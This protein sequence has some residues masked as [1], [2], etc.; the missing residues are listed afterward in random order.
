MSGTTRFE[1]YLS[2]R[3]FFRATLATGSLVV[4]PTFGLAPKTAS[5]FEPNAFVRIDPDGQVTIRVARPEL[6]QGVHTSLP[7][8]VAEELDVDWTQIR[9]EPAL[10]I[11]RNVYGDQYAGGS[12]SVRNG[13]EPLRRAGAIARAMLVQAAARRWHVQ[14]SECRTAHGAV[15]HEPSKRHLPYGAL[16]ARAASLPVPKDVP[17]K[18]ANQYHFIGRPM[19]QRAT[20]DIV[21]GA[22]VFGLDTRLPGMRYASIEHA[23][24]LGARVVA[25]DESAARSIAGVRDVVTVN[26]D[27]LPGFGDNNPR[28]ANGV[29]VIADSTWSALKGRRALKVTWSEGAVEEDTEQRRTE[30]H[31]LSA[32]PP[33]RVVRSDGDVERA[34]GLATRTL[35]AVYEVP[36]LAHVPMEPMNCVADVRADRCDV[37]APTQNPAA[38]RSVAAA[39]CG[40][41]VESVTVHTRRC[42]GGFGRRF[43]ADYVAEATVLSRAAGKPVQVMWTREDDVR[44]DY[45]RPASC[46]QMRAALD[47]RGELVAWTQH[48]VQA[49]RGDFLQWAPPA[50]ET[51]LP[52]GDEI[53][54]YDFPAGYVPN[55]RL[56]AS[57]IRD[58]PVPLGQW[59]SVDE[60]SNVFV[61]QSFI[62]ELAHLAGRDPLD[63]RLEIIGAPRPL[64]YGRATY[65]CGRLRKVFELAAERSSWGSSLPSGGG[66]GIAGC[67]AN[68]AY[69]AVAAEVE[70]SDERRVRVRRLVM[71]ADIGTVINPLGAIA[72]IEGSAVF[73]LSAALK[74][75]ITIVHGR[76]AQGNFDDFDVLRM[77]DMPHI[78]VHLVPSTEPPLGIGEPAVPPVAPAVTN[79]IFA[80]SGVRVRRLPIRVADFRAKT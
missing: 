77:A 64:P 72:Q 79:A 58:C 32:G 59:R 6:G 76:V 30:C 45:F 29:A 38:A 69:V 35:E 18:K 56:M 26:A 14:A 33:Q 50:G 19:L 47:S 3:E 63:Y 71:A 16:A 13:W 60:F 34:F 43:Y 48:L 23:P 15:I 20:A 7:M 70:V 74:E 68:H 39:I 9:I 2:R 22:Q 5:R 40:L 54:D 25:V 75:E 51:R 24:V 36:L 12:Q 27:A 78:E 61:Y 8:I 44:H 31:K 28:P 53:G 11:D 67:Y 41:P 10:G 52:A 17:P 62:D 57:A 21:T 66:R 46:H 4:F 37:W 80:A 49:Q 65:D 73:A 42:G 1:C 55:L